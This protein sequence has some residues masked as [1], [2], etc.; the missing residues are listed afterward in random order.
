MMKPDVVRAAHD[1]SF[2]PA[3]SRSEHWEMTIGA[4]PVLEELLARYRN[5]FEVVNR[6]EAAI[7]A[8]AAF[9]ALG[10]SFTTDDNADLLVRSNGAR[11]SREGELFI[12]R[13]LVVAIAPIADL[14]V[15]ILQTHGLRN[16]VI[17]SQVCCVLVDRSFTAEGM[18]VKRNE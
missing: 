9:R 4:Q 16:S 7:L 18:R 2:P 10:R 14:Q 11:W 5:S 3:T 13:C 15:N 8:I 1:R 12:T 17:A 6:A